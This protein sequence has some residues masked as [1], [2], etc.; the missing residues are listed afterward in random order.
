MISKESKI[1]GWEMWN[2]RFRHTSNFQYQYS[3]ILLNQKEHFL[4]FYS[5]F[6]DFVVAKSLVTKIQIQIWAY[7]NDFHWHITR[8]EASTDSL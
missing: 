6:P 7:T 1:T 8:R 3:P 2:G 4:S 5:R